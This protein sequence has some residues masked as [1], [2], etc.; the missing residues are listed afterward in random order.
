MGN[1]FITRRGGGSPQGFF[2]SL[3][4][5]GLDQTDTCRAT[6]NGKSYV[7]VWTT[8]D[9]SSGFYFNKLQELGTY[10]VSN[11]TS[12]MDILVDAPI[13][14]TLEWSTIPRTDLVAE[15]LFDGDTTDT[16][17]NGN[18]LTNSG[19][20]FSNN[21]G[22]FSGSAKAI[23]SQNLIADSTPYS[24]SAWFKTTSTSGGIIGFGD[25]GTDKKGHMIRVDSGKIQTTASKGTS[26]THAFNYSTP[27]T[28]NDGLW[29]HLVLT[30][31]NGNTNNLK[32]YVDDVLV[33]NQNTNYTIANMT[34]QLTTIGCLWSSS[35]ATYLNGSLD[36]IRIYSRVLTDTEIATLYD[37]G[38]VIHPRTYLYK[39][40]NECSDITGGWSGFSGIGSSK[41]VGFV[42]ANK[43]DFSKYSTL[44]IQYT[45]TH[46]SSYGRAFSIGI[47]SVYN[48]SGT[49]ATTVNDILNTSVS[50]S[51]TKVTTSI[52]ISSI[53]SQ[54]YLSLWDGTSLNS[55]TTYSKNTDSLYFRGYYNASNDSQTNIYNVWLE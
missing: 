37:E 16:S 36:N 52:N 25:Y 18:D 11:G 49:Y 35:Y 20:T 38:G 31:D 48:D 7:G 1:C 42:E 23:A 55:N 6:C 39:E 8:T 9:T 40:G 29:H 27:S 34:N 21:V 50:S 32:L 2:P 5:T 17:P 22:V 24:I 3:F 51:G 45:N 10:T 41:K 14:Y 12:T 28:Y 4:V 54:G 13:E 19:V 44:N 46:T 15:Y 53:T 43:I 26:G 33:I 30:N 47:G